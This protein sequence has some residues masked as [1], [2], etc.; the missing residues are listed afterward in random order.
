MDLS[1]AKQRYLQFCQEQQF[2]VWVHNDIFLAEVL[3][4]R[5]YAADL[6]QQKIP[7]NERVEFLWDALLGAMVAQRLRKDYPER[8]EAELTLKKIYLIKEPTLATVARTIWL[9]N[10]IRLGKWEEKSWWREKD[11]ILADACE[12]W[13]AYLRDQFGRDVADRFVEAYL[14]PLHTDAE[15]VRWKSYKSLL[16]ERVQKTYQQLPVYVE[17]EWVKEASWNVLN[18]ISRVYVN[19]ELLA[20]ATAQN[21]R[22]AQEE[23]ARLAYE[24]VVGT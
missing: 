3:T 13:I 23:A 10:R 9:W 2:S 8:S 21:K 17:E 6:P 16:Q 1:A 19:D 14:Y 7:Y 15:A 11:V 22:K 20:E 4:H 18:Y 5:S 24:V 12:A